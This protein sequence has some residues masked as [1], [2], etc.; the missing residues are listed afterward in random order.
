MSSNVNANTSFNSAKLIG[1]IVILL[2]G[3]H[4]L[5]MINKFVNSLLLWPAGP[6]SYTAAWAQTREVAKLD[7]HFGCLDDNRYSV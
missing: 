7:C 1:A 4:W 3:T 5:S 6:R 2:P